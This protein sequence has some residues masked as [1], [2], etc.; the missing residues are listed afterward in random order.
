MTGI[1]TSVFDGLPPYPGGKR[2]LIRLILAL[3]NDALPHECW[4][5]ATFVD[6]FFGG[7]AVS[8][9]AKAAGFQV[10]AGDIAERSAIVGRG[11]VANSRHR[12]DPR[13]PLRF[14]E[15][16][17][18]DHLVAEPAILRQLLG[19][20]RAF[21]RA[22]WLALSDQRD[23][24]L[25]RDLLA[26]VAIKLILRSFPLSLP[27]ASDAGHVVAGDYDRLTSARTSHYLRHAPVTA[28]VIVRTCAAVNASVFAGR[29][30]FTKGSALD[31]LAADADVAVLDPPYPGTQSYERA[32]RLLDDYLGDP[33]G[34]TNPYSGSSPPIDELLD[35]CR[36]IP[37]VVLCAGNAQMDEE[38]WAALVGRHRRVLKSIAVPYR[39]YAAVA[40]ER[41][42]ATNCEFLIL[43]SNEARR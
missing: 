21:A 22:A 5:D 29:A 25:D 18:T 34:E 40:S 19:P 15:S 32:F 38:G 36:H 7:G 41:K 16:A 33:P 12:L 1:A 13:H 28:E 20:R 14:L 27:N 8:I 2:R 43:S 10:R 9:A 23:A 17:K 42:N 37:L 11:L 24:G 26:I 31:L 6:P 35:A 3:I 39:H 4:R 30:T